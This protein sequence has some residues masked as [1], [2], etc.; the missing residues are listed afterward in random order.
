M[1]SFSSR[2][3]FLLPLGK[4][5]RLGAQVP[6]ERLKVGFPAPPPNWINSPMYI[7]SCVRRVLSS[8]QTQIMVLVIHFLEHRHPHACWQVYKDAVAAVVL[9]AARW[10]TL[11]SCSPERWSPG[12]S[13]YCPLSPPDAGLVWK[14]NTLTRAEGSRVAHLQTCLLAD[15]TQDSKVTTKVTF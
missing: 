6:G 13:G 12:V 7:I 11:I 5:A 1:L 9:G 10:P 2:I 14:I 8:H 15:G 4:Q 3:R